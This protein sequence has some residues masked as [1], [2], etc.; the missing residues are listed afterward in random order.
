MSNEY[1]MLRKGFNN[2]GVDV[3]MEYILLLSST[4]VI[5]KSP[6]KYLSPLH[7]SHLIYLKEKYEK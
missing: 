3:A 6:S 7:S 2:L 5:R 4:V 1:L